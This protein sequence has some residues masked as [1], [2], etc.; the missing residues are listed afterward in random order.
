MKFFDLQKYL[1]ANG[2]W[3]LLWPPHS[4]QSLCFHDD[5]A[6][7]QISLFLPVSHLLS[8]P[9][10]IFCLVS[11]ALTAIS[12]PLPT[13]SKYIKKKKPTGWNI[14][15]FHFCLGKLPSSLR[16]KKIH[17]CL[18]CTPSTIKVCIYYYNYILL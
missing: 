6:S 10:N 14:S 12:L 18:L 13:I 4:S 17:H 15:H 16:K 2:P 11:H 1:R 5:E 8:H 7:D 3:N 9:G